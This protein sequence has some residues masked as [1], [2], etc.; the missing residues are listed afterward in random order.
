MSD[1]AAASAV[2]SS[3]TTTSSGA[4]TADS[5]EP[6]KS[7]RRRYFTNGRSRTIELSTLAEIDEEDPGEENVYQTSIFGDESRPK[8]TQDDMFI[9]SAPN[10]SIKRGSVKS[11]ALKLSEK[12][13]QRTESRLNTE[14]DEEMMSQQSCSNRHSFSQPPPPGAAFAEVKVQRNFSDCRKEARSCETN[15]FASRE[16]PQPDMFQPNFQYPMHSRRPIS[17]SASFVTPTPLLIYPMVD[18]RCES[19]IGEY[20]MPIYYAMPPPQP[21]PMFLPFG[22][23]PASTSKAVE[24]PMM[25]MHSF[26]VPPPP[27]KLMRRKMATSRKKSWCSRICC[28]GLAQLL[29]TIVCIISF[30]IIASLI[31]ALCYM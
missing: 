4:L 6:A 11:Q 22:A 13:A 5:S 10:R 2:S 15:D 14:K 17:R 12:L 28:A 25:M 19:R 30:G 18:N 3:T 9:N 20:A 27:Q 31:L 21:P 16:W 23:T 29:W 7:K 26:E 24:A 8:S 1:E